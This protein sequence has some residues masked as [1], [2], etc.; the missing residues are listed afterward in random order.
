MDPVDYHKDAIIVHPEEHGEPIHQMRVFN[1]G[2]TRDANT[3]KLDYKGFISPLAMER[4][5][6]YM[7]KHRKQSD[8]S[9]RASDNWKKGIPLDAYMESLVRHVFEVWRLY[10]NGDTEQT[11]ELMCAVMFNAQGF[12]HERAKVKQSHAITDSIYE[13]TAERDEN[14]S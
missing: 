11:E 7:H 6:A 1:T 13:Q 14:C 3:D 8:G 5:S 9:I 4:F 2:A 12:L 10:E